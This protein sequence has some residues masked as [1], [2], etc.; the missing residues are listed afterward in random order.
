MWNEGFPFK[1]PAWTKATSGSISQRPLHRRG[2][3]RWFLYSA[4][5]YSDSPTTRVRLF[6]AA[7]GLAYA[8]ALPSGFI[9]SLSVLTLYAAW[10]DRDAELEVGTFADA[11]IASDLF[12]LLLRRIRLLDEEMNGNLLKRTSLGLRSMFACLHEGEDAPSI[13]GGIAEEKAPLLEEQVLRARRL[14]DLLK[15]RLD[16]GS[17]RGTMTEEIGKL[18]ENLN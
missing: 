9:R 6:N 18:L 11:S 7:K 12:Y 16:V 8:W 17:N 2:F 14:V 5:N 10:E 4:A 3:I 13:V 1:P 15:D